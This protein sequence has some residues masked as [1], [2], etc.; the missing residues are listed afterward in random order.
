[1]LKCYKGE[2]KGGVFM[3][4]SEGMLAFGIVL[5][6]II[7]I[8]VYFIPTII[9]FSKGRINKGAIFCMNLFLGWAFIGWVVALI[10]AV[11]NPEQVIKIENDRKY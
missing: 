2:W 9:A 4:G 6:A 8:L 11:K 5:L 7:G 3:D 1:M 10:W